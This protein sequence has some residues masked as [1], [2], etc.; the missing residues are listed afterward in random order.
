MQSCTVRPSQCILFRSQR[1]AGEL[2]VGAD[3]CREAANPD[4]YQSFPQ[5]K[6]TTQG[7]FHL[8]TCGPTCKATGQP[9]DRHCSYTLR[10]SLGAFKAP[11]FSGYGSQSGNDRA[12]D[13]LSPALFPGAKGLHAVA[14]VADVL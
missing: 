5:P 11:T 9:L 14:W 12:V 8:A 13:R 4:L 1:I 2:F 6:S 3:D 7:H 10:T